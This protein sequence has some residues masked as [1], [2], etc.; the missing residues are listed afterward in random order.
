MQKLLLLEAFFMENSMKKIWKIESVSQMYES[1]GYKEEEL[2]NVLEEKDKYYKNIVKI[3]KKMGY[4]EICIIDKS[5]ELYELQ[6]SL[7]INFLDNIKISDIAYGFRKNYDYFDFL[8]AHRNFYGNANY[9]RIDISN[10]F[11]SISEQMIIDTFEY[12]VDSLEK[13]KILK[14]LLDIML[15]NGVL[16]QGTPIAPVVSNIIFRSIDIRIQRY[17][18]KQRVKYSRYV[19]DLL[20]SS[21]EHGKIF[22]IN[23]CKTIERILQSE[24]FKINYS[25]LRRAQNR[26]SINGF[27]VDENVR[28]SRKKLAPISRIL[29]YMEANKYVKSEDWILNYNE[30]MQK[31]IKEKNVQIEGENDLINLLAGYRAFL[32]NALK[33]SEDEYFVRRIKGIIKRTEKQINNIEK[34]K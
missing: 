7:R 18:D 12:Y 3:P 29:Y 23:F 20:F 31:Y 30:E 15:Y 6:K 33:H 1:L 32:I 28:L 13:E 2:I 22:N 11:R 4:R 9:L 34:Q 14:C 27:C 24:G 25:K 17:C 16:I 8:E 21:E 10:F 26:I 5:C 19:D